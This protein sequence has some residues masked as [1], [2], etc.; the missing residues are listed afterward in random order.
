[1]PFIF[2]PPEEA[3]VFRTQFAPQVQ[4]SLINRV[5]D[6]TLV[7]LLP[8]FHE[9]PCAAPGIEFTVGHLIMLPQ[10]LGKGKLGV[11]MTTTGLR[12]PGIMLNQAGLRVR[13]PLFPLFS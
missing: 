4:V 12:I 1:M 8:E 6:P 10:P 9:L 5:W 3:D 13:I 7:E 2:P 11:D